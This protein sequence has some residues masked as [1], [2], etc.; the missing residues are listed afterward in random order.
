M[1]LF[2]DYAWARPAPAAIK[3][4]GYSG[5][6]R[7]LSP[8][9]S[10]NL[11]PDERDRLLAAGLSIGLVWESYAKRAAQGFAAGAADAVSAE[12]QAAALDCP[13]WVILFYAVDFDADPASVAAYF[14]GVKS[15][16]TRP[17]GVYGGKRIVEGVDV[18]Y[19][20]QAS[21]W[22]SRMIAGQW[23]LEVSTQAH[24]FQRQRAT[25]ANP[26]PSTDENIVLIDFPTWT[27]VPLVA[28]PLPPVLTTSPAST[29]NAAQ[30][31]AIQVAC[32]VPGD[33]KWGDETSKAATAVIR[34]ILTDV[35]YLQARV[36]TKV[37]GVWGKNSEA[38]RIAAVKKIQAAINVAADGVWGAKSQAAW[39]VAYLNNFKK[40]L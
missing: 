10:K 40:Y 38:A 14:A 22:S 25:V 12:A 35:R 20:W 32:H 28:A 2:L 31:K 19:K 1:T 5:V 24:L 21:A 7:Y 18:Q 27:S 11:S 8:D 4:A 9:S 6:M 16:A 13:A 23:V 29:W 37:D 34:R 33:G 26:V 17:V 30:T 15:K 3:A 36:G 39:W